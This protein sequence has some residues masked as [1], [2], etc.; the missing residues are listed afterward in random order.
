MEA[1]ETTGREERSTF[2]TK[3]ERT[4]DE[5]KEQQKMGSWRMIMRCY[6]VQEGYTVLLY[7]RD[8]RDKKERKK[9]CFS[10]ILFSCSYLLLK[11]KR[12]RGTTRRRERRERKE[13]RG[14]RMP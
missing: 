13:S 7:V 12:R 10:S 14:E 4:E 3:K 1:G 11:K 6:D 9:A 5:E 2:I 8:V